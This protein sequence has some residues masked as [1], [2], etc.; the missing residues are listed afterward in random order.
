MR[1]RSARLSGWYTTCIEFSRFWASRMDVDAVDPT[2][3]LSVV[4]YVYSVLFL[5]LDSPELGRASPGPRIDVAGWE[6]CM[7][8][9]RR[10]D[11]FVQRPPAYSRRRRG[12]SPLVSQN[13]YVSS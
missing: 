12:K 9:V 4:A 6:L 1:E 2:D 10:L 8:I 5:W 7:R 3:L 13:Y 11:P